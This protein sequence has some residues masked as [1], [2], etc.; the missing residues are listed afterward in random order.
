M[1]VVVHSEPCK[2]AFHEASLSPICPS[3]LLSGTLRAF[4]SMAVAFATIPV[5]PTTVRRA[6]TYI[7]EERA[8][9]SK[10]DT[11]ASVYG[12]ALI[13]TNVKKHCCASGSVNNETAYA[14]SHLGRP[15][16]LM[17]CTSMEAN[18]A[19]KN[20]EKPA[21]EEAVEA[22]GFKYRHSI[23]TMKVRSSAKHV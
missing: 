3:T 23:A 6:R 9:A 14:W 20:R 21:L 17:I 15:W 11:A 16:L 12:L 18:A 8:S 19:N 22:T 13:N 7:P 5:C 4:E 10:I 2:V 1:V